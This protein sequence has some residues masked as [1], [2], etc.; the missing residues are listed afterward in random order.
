MKIGPVTEEQIIGQ[1]HVSRTREPKCVNRPVAG[2]LSLIPQPRHPMDLFP[3]I[4]PPRG[5]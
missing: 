1:R 4:V 3:K 2:F 5:S